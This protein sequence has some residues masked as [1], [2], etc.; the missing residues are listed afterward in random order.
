MDII[1]AIISC[2]ALLNNG[3]QKKKNKEKTIVYK[4]Q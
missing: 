3:Q 1:L 4:A 2:L